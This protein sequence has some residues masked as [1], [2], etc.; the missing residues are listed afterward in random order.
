MDEAVRR[1]CRMI[2]KAKAESSVCILSEKCKTYIAQ[3]LNKD[4]TVAAIAAYIGVNPSYLS[5][6]FSNHEHMTIKQYITHEKI[7]A[8]KNML[9]YS[10][11]SIS[12]VVSYLNFC[13][14]SYFT[15]CFKKE[16]GLTP[17]RYR[18]KNRRDT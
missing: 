10:D 3:N 17:S 14:Q 1:I 6:T 15:E 9:K 7:N 8:A 11:Y 12:E 2:K 4:V 13:S 18:Q 16:V 5:A